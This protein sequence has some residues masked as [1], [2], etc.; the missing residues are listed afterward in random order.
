[1][2]NFKSLENTSYADLAQCINRAF[3]DYA[4]NISVDEHM[5]KRLYVEQNVDLSLSFGA[6]DGDELVGVIINAFGVYGGVKAV[7]DV[8]TGVVPEH[9]SSG[10][11]SKLFDYGE[12][13]LGECGIDK[14]FLEV[15][16]QNEKAIHI[17]SKKGFIKCREFSVLMC[18]K[19][20]CEDNAS[21][22]SVCP[23]ED[24]NFPSGEY[25]VSEP[26]FENCNDIISKNKQNY[27]V[28]YTD[29]AYCIYS[30]QNGDTA[31]IACLAYRDMSDLKATVTHLCKTFSRVLA[32]N[33]DLSCTELILTLKDIGFKEL[34]RQY[35]MYKNCR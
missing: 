2:Y 15:L 29:K 31:H 11:F 3:S 16:Q 1:M 5:L 13:R 21:E 26:S 19:L 23:F 17:Y 30:V 9:R 24:F 35:E 12:K 22:I 10:V 4:L 28:M 27:K 33:I 6:F 20:N 7:F 25:T 34:T 14:Y 18:E 32:K 8:A